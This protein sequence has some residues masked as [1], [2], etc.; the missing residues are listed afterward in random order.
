MQTM[1]L[2]RA[3]EALERRDDARAVVVDDDV[4]DDL[5]ADV[6]ERRREPG[7]VRVDEL[8]ARE[9]GPDAQDGAR[10]GIR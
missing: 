3:R 2:A 1:T 10:H 8:A 6:G 7:R 4:L 9:L 5:E